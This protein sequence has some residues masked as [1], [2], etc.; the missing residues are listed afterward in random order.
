MTTSNTFGEEQVIR[1]CCR[2]CHGGC[3]VLVHVKDGI[4]V[5][6]E[7]DPECPTNHGT[8]CTKGLA[9]I[10]LVYHPDRITHPLK[11]TGKRGEGKWQRI[12]WDEALD[13]I[14]DNLERVKKEYGVESI[15]TGSGT[16]RD[17]GV[18]F[19]RF[20]RL[21]G[22]PN[23]YSPGHVCRAPRTRSSSIISGA[24][25]LCDYD[26]KPKCVLVWGA[27]PVWSNPDE[28]TGE[29]L[30]TTLSGG[31]KLIVVD[32]RLT[33]LAGRADVWLQPRPGT[34]AALALGIANVI[35]S[36]RLYDKEFV[37]KYIYGWDK[38]VERV[39]E[40]PLEKVE[41]ITWVPVNKIREA[42]RLYAQ[43]KPSGIHSGVGPDQGINGVDTARSIFSLTAITGNLD[44]PGGNVFFI[45][46]LAGLSSNQNAA[47]NFNPKHLAGDDFKIGQMT[48]LTTPKLLYK[49]ILTGKPYPLKAMHLHGANPLLTRSNANEIYKALCH[50]DFISVADFFL[51][52]TVELAD[53]VLPAATWLEQ[54][55]VAND[56]WQYSYRIPRRKVVQIGE[57]RSDHQILNDLGKRMGQKWGKNVEED[58][59]SILEEEGLTWQQFKEMPYLK[60]D[61][62]YRKHEKTGFSTPTGK[63]ELYSTVIEKLGYDP[64]P[65]YREIPES[66]VSQPELHKEYPYILTTGARQPVYFCSEGRMI[67]WLRE[68][69]PDPIIEIHPNTAQMHGIKDGDWVIIE[70]LRGKIRQKAYLTLGIDP[71]VVH[72]EYGWWFSEVTSPDHGWRE[73]NAN[74]LTDNNPDTCDPAMGS[75]NLR[76]T[77][78]KIYPAG[79]GK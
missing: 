42:A 51:T 75:T 52:P 46:P 13:T 48:G 73:S 58:L 34:D 17:W 36:E 53:I 28:Y 15:V 31:A 20:V 67:P 5:K 1:S 9:A 45:R 70:S 41:E 40:Y 18:W 16:G 19:G 27:N 59:D 71:R 35:I 21:L 68:I 24:Y 69:H 33:Y 3:G 78:C 6:I 63:V 61:M 37:D 62:E 11:R 56:F 74:V 64:L 30:M 4:I 23:N 2:G 79:E 57:C 50:L 26:G 38:F 76:A 22:S 12:S 72:T 14:V 32:P 25:S 10:Q 55:G 29:N 44:V 47:F 8:M 65:Q 54:D 7:G 77:L 49:A 66:P 60:A 43:T 39:N